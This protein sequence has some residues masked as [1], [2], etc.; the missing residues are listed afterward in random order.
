MSYPGLM[1]FIVII[2]CLILN[3]MIHDNVGDDKDKQKLHN[4]VD[5][6]KGEFNGTPKHILD[7][8]ISANKRFMSTFLSKITKYN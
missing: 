5:Q 8:Y 3:C 7:S 1:F 6:K 4:S 2:G